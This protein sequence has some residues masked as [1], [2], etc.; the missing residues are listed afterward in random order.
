MSEQAGW[1]GDAPHPSEPQM[2]G[3]QTV[4]RE[5]EPPRRISADSFKNL[6]AKLKQPVTIHSSIAVQSVV[7]P[8]LR[9]VTAPAAAPV[10]QPVV[11]PI[12]ILASQQPTLPV[13][14][15]PHILVSAPPILPPPVPV[16]QVAKTPDP[17]PVEPSPQP[18]HSRRPLVDPELEAVMRQIAAVPSSE[19][20]IQ[21][22]DEAVSIVVVDQVNAA[23]SGELAA[24]EEAYLKSL[25][26]TPEPVDVAP[27]LPAQTTALDLTPTPAPEIPAPSAALQIAEPPAALANLDESEATEVS[28]SLLD[29]MAAGT[30]SGQPQERALAADTLLR[31]VPRLPLKA[32]VLLSDR[33]SI[34]DAPPHLLIAKL[35]RDPRIEVSGPLLENSM[36]ITDQDLNS[37][38]G[39]SDSAKRRMVARRR[40]LSREISDQLILTGDSSV[41]LTLVRN[42]NAEI[43][44]DG[45]LGL[46]KA[47][48]NDAG[49]LAPLCT[50]A[51]LPAPFAFELFWI[52][53]VQLRRYIL[54]RFLTDSETLTKILKITLST[55]GDDESADSQFPSTTEVRQFIEQMLAGQAGQACENFASSMRIAAATVARIVADEQGE[56]IAVLM[57]AAGCPRTDFQAYLQS[58]STTALPL[59]PQRLDDLHALFDSLSFNKARILLTYWDW[60]ERK[61]G[62]Y[63]PLH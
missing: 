5:G 45:F 62:P 48:N 27:V 23:P 24:L 55:Q 28:R 54:H 2:I 21:F 61:A 20:R 40:K 56:P 1:R 34:M 35:I 41:A 47:A 19:D 6:M 26:E 30:H 59:L 38:I 18:A 51:D 57:K 32:M 16:A 44:H 14:I 13:E 50:R 39:E 29:M 8:D 37:A 43:S 7:I 53:P 10:V 49:L 11:A 63:A 36:H 31:L 60:A 4:A 46:C 15:S 17:D 58:L 12:E 9:P 25:A 42:T 3:S 33:L 22:L 52:A